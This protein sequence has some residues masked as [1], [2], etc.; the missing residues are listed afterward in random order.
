MLDLAKLKSWS[1]VRRLSNFAGDRRGVSAVEFAMLMPLL[2]G[3]YLSCV[4]ITQG[5]TI[6]RKVTLTSHTVADLASQVSTLSNNDVTNI[7]NASASVIAPYAPGLL[8]ITLTCVDIDSTGKAKVKWSE[9]LNGTAR[10]VGSTVTLAAALAVPSTS[11]IWAEV[12]YAYTPT[13][14]YNITGT[15]NLFDQIY[16]RPRVSDTITRTT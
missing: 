10:A 15:L 13:I 16:M 8:K 12:S 7:L 3:L 5:V 6:D 2:V 9:T 14:G 11:L 1:F 4:E